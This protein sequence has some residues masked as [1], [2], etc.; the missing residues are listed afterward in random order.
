MR[1]L[2]VL[3]LI[4]LQINS[5]GAFEMANDY[6][7][8]QKQMLKNANITL[9]PQLKSSR[10]DKR[11]YNDNRPSPYN[12]TLLINE[13]TLCSQ[14]KKVFLLIAI[15]T[16]Y[17]HIERRKTLRESF[18]LKPNLGLNDEIVVKHVFLF[19]NTG[20]P[21]VEK[22]IRKES[23]E[24][25]DILQADYIESYSNL[26]YKSVM[27][28]KWCIDYC[29]NTEYVIVMNDELLF[30]IGKV[31][32]FLI[33]DLIMGHVDDHF[34]I[35]FPI[36]NGAVIHFRMKQFQVLDRKIMYQGKFTPMY[37]HGFGYAAHITVINK[38]Y[39]LSQ[40]NTFYMPDDI[41]IGVMSERLRLKI[42]NHRHVYVL[43]NIEKYFAAEDYTLKPG[44]IAVSDFGK[45]KGY[46]G[47]TQQN[48][49]LILRK[50]WNR[51]FKVYNDWQSKPEEV[52]V[53]T[54][55]VLFVPFIIFI[56]FIRRLLGVFKI[57]FI[58]KK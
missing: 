52:C 8:S 58:I 13:E 25:R 1:Y 40:R 34:A 3:L 12:G 23:N 15:R 27:A 44:M 49:L 18:H 17:S 45:L 22:L 9:Y 5:E 50:H 4:F 38:L 43:K 2:Q 35:C 29:P 10:T 57:L 28:W 19:G 32:L 24:Y 54:T 41:W 26:T 16:I 7:N 48:V 39:Q 53:S 14:H 56:F 37:C 36:G 11:Y 20:N 42:P 47:R 51:S 46:E 6:F 30:D 55:L 21:S 33:N 31:L